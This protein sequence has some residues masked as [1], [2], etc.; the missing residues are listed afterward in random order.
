MTRSHRMPASSRKQREK[1]HRRNQIL[2]AAEEVFRRKGYQATTMDEVA[3]EAEFSKGTLY[4]YFGSKFALFSELS[5]RVLMVVHGEFTKISEE[6]ITGRQ[7]VG[8]MLRLWAGEMSSNIRR[9]RLAISWIASDDKQDEDCPGMSS[10]RETMASVIGILSSAIAL[11]QSD[12]SVS[13]PGN[14]TILACQVWSGMVGAL[15]FSSRVE[16]DGNRFPVTINREDFMESFVDLLSCG[17]ASK[18]TAE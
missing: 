6:P 1:E 4:L 3:E 2:E 12:G 7:K 11:G 17:L 18:E 10:H 8:K 13:N 5:N 16:Q 15:L 9:F 14:P